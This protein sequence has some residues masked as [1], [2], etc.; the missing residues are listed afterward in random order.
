MGCRSRKKSLEIKEYRSAEIERVMIDS[1]NRAVQSEVLQSIGQNVRKEMRN[2]QMT[3]IRIKGKTDSIRP[4][5]IHNIVNGDTLSDI[6]ISGDAIFEITQRAEKANA[7]TDVRQIV[8]KTNL[9]ERFA[10]TAV[11]QETI[12]K[13]ANF[14]K[15]KAVEVKAQGV[16]VMG[17]VTIIIGVVL[18]IAI[19]A[20]FIYSRL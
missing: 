11:S 2:T 16:G 5:T 4:F 10:R 18:V 14:I 6:V 17:W 20:L 19:V 1:T 7:Y 15:E 13:S 12:K 3:D 9:L 8:D